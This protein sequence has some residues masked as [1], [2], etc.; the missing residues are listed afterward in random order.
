MFRICMLL[1]FLFF[2]TSIFRYVHTGASQIMN[3]GTAFRCENYLRICRS[4]SAEQKQNSGSA[5]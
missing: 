3:N 4:S 5:V 2:D 1:C